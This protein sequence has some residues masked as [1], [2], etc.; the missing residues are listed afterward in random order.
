MRVGARV[1]PKMEATRSLKEWDE[2]VA[3]TDSRKL[4]SG[5][6]ME[7]MDM[8]VGFAP[9]SMSYT[10][11][12]DEMRYSPFFALDEPVR[13]PGPLLRQIGT[14]LVRQVGKGEQEGSGS[15]L[16][17]A[18][19][20]RPRSTRDTRR[21]VRLSGSLWCHQWDQE[22]TSLRQKKNKHIS[23]TRES[24]KRIATYDPWD[25]HHS[26]LYRSHPTI[27]QTFSSV[28]DRY[29]TLGHRPTPTP[30]S[31]RRLPARR[32]D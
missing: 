20:V 10:A 22:S 23:N 28:L 7:G 9:E 12:G 29:P 31:E 19:R 2:W 4:R 1:M 13:R 24:K 27:P 18:G 30:Q 17:L 5:R 21:I 25:H 32:C 15:R 26:C 11:I 6:G 3:S 16:H 14:L 8:G